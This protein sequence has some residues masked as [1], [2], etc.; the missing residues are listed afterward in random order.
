MY[1]ESE[2]APLSLYISCVM[3]RGCNKLVSRLRRT[4]IHALFRR[5][6][7]LP[8]VISAA[9]G[10]NVAV[11]SPVMIVFLNM[12]AATPAAT[13]A[14]AS[15]PKIVARIMSVQICPL[16]PFSSCCFALIWYPSSV[17][18]RLEDLLLWTRLLPPSEVDHRLPDGD[19][20]S[21]RLRRRSQ[22]EVR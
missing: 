7:H 10:P 11:S 14:A 21:V 3:D 2:R 1:R 16:S 18:C 9:L 6:G 4:K 5:S 22:A 12:N 20:P 8:A 19:L 15:S 17:V 13:T